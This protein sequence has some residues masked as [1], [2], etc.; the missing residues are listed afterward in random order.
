MKVISQLKQENNQ[1]FRENKIKKSN[2]ILAHRT[3]EV[4]IQRII[5][6]NINRVYGKHEHVIRYNK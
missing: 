3:F 4:Q 6:N 5:A 2:R 1:I